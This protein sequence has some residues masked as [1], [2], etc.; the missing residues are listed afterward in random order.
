MEMMNCKIKLANNKFILVAAY[1]SC[2]QQFHMNLKRGNYGRQNL[3]IYEKG[4]GTSLP[5]NCRRRG[6]GHMFLIKAGPLNRE[7]RNIYR[8]LTP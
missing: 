2:L 4:I 6:E 7:G 5:E 1:H 3:N 8:E